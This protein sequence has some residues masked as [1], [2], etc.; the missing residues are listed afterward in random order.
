M[1]YSVSVV[2]P[3]WNGVDF[4]ESC[5]LSLKK[6]TFKHHVIVVDNGSSDNS[7]EI[8]KKFK[9]VE[10]IELSKNT[11]FTG[12]VN[13]G[14]ERAL[15]RGDEFVAL[16][17]ND[18][19]ADKNWLKELVRPIAKDKGTVICTSKIMRSDKKHLDSTGDFLT[20][21]GLPFP[22]GR[23]EADAG[24]YNKPEE[25]FGASG[26][27][28]IYRCS[29]LKEY[30]LFD[31]SF[32]AYYED[33]DMSF[34]AQLAGYN[35]RYEPKAVVYHEIGATSSKLG[36]FTRYH[37]LKNFELLYY[38]NMPGWLFWKYLPLKS[39]QYLRMAAG[40]VRDGQI[41]ALAKSWVVTVILL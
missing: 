24:Q 2:I 20:I 35:V 12:G 29:F 26:G 28:S 10:L 7:V 31:Q 11:G 41:W 8:I 22:R 37:S 1:K 36:S 33:V 14:I 4:I 30:G 18:A 17:N 34:R 3:N 5:L 6:Q 40:A 16:L 23:N 15:E 9:E 19:V 32:F 21:W 39:I 27:A 25:V 38:K 13:T